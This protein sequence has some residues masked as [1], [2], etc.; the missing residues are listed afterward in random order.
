MVVPQTV[1]RGRLRVR[2]GRRAAPPDADDD[3]VVGDHV[4]RQIGDDRIG[5]LLGPETGVA[6]GAAVRSCSATV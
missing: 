4:G 1:P 5:E 3:D 6:S 2:P